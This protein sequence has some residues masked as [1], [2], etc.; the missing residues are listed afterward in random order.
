MP[1]V[2]SS[3]SQDGAC[4]CLALRSSFHYSL[5]SSALPPPPSLFPRP[6]AFALREA[7]SDACYFKDEAMRAFK[8]GVLSLEERAQV[9]WAQGGPRSLPG[10]THPPL[11][12]PGTSAR[13]TQTALRAP[14]VWHRFVPLAPA[15]L[16][17]LSPCRLPASL[18]PPQMDMMFDA[19]CERIRELAVAHD[20]PLPDAL[21]PDA[22][23]PGTKMY[24]VNM[25]GAEGAGWQAR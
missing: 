24:H 16:P 8:L 21:R 14:C 20:L 13:S 10:H 4:C 12:Q 18:L 22:A 9:R 2:A 17:S 11:P 15:H 23:A 6:D 7:F 3:A 1:P 5:S 19:A 25:S